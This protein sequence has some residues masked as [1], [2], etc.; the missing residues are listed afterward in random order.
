MTIQ[1][2]YEKESG[3]S[4]SNRPINDTVQKGFIIDYKIVG[5]VKNTNYLIGALKRGS[6]ISCDFIS[7]NDTHTINENISDNYG[8]IY[9]NI[10]CLDKYSNS[11]VTKRKRI[12]KQPVLKE[13]EIDLLSNDL[14]W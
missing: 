9:V 3:N 10:G 14:E 12:K 1:D 7:T 4:Y 11:V 8:Y 13:K 6:G 5:Y 2:I